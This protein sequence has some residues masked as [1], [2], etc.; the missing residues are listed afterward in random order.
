M[1]KVSALGALSNAVLVCNTVRIA[2]HLTSRDL[3]RHGNLA[4]TASAR[5]KNPKGARRPTC[6]PALRT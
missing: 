5:G 4:S 1:N 2:D 3:D 6:G